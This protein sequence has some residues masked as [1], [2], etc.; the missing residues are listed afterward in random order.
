MVIN[1][2]TFKFS[3]ITLFWKQNKWH[4]HG[5]LVHTLKVAYHVIASKNYKMIPAAFL[6]D[7]GKPGVS[8]QDEEDI[9]LNTYSFTDH[10]ER[11]YQLIKNFS[12]ISD[13]TKNL[14][15]YHYLI[16]DMSN[17]K[18]KGMFER[19]AQKKDAWDSLTPEFQKDLEIFI[20][21][22]D[23]GKQ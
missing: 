8:Y 19:Y 18:R 16:R 17:C 21:L 2:H 10:E 7:I 20:K 22:D 4:K 15:R 6:H 5:V 14:V 13:Y 12:F 3:I 1:P 23:K 11:S 9:E